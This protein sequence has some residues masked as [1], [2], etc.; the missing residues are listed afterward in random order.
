[1]FVKLLQPSK[2]SLPILT[3][4]YGRLIWVK[5]LQLT[6]HLSPIVSIESERDIFVNDEQSLKQNLS[7]K[8]IEVGRII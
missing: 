7:S 3:K 1:L 5:V 8:V 6:K 2:T 4:D